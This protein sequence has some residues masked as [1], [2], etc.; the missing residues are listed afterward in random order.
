MTLVKDPTREYQA[1]QRVSE[2]EASCQHQSSGLIPAQE[3]EYSAT[4]GYFE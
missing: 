1:R 4:G 3:Q 2:N